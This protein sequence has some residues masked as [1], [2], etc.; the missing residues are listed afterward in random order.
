[1]RQLLCTLAIL[2]LATP[3]RAQFSQ[4]PPDE[5]TPSATPPAAPAPPPAAATGEAR[6]LIQR[7]KQKKTVGGTLIIF[8]SFL[9]AGG[10]GLIIADTVGHNDCRACYWD[11][12]SITGIVFDVV[13][14]ACIAGG[15]TTY[16]IGGTQ[17]DQGQRLQGPNL[18]LRF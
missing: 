7:G 8:G 15:I 2:T 4:P 16:V 11:A 9:S 6:D 10:S 14:T 12:L 5:P 13:G 1:M 17:V 18:A 3:A